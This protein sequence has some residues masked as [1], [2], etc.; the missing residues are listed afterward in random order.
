MGGLR[1]A[2][3]VFRRPAA[4]LSERGAKMAVALG[5]VVKLGVHAGLSS[6]RSRVQ[7][8]SSPPAER[9]VRSAR[10]SGAR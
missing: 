3:L 5:G 2:I 9:P 6:R 10:V 4:P 1:W 7:I 8:P